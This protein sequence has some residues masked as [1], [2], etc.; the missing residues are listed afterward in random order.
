MDNKHA[1]YDLKQMQS[2]PLG[3]KIEMSKRRIKEWYEYWDGNVY[4]SF[5]GGKDSTVLLR[6]VREIYPDV[7]GVFVDTGL[8][9]PEIKEFVKTSDNIDWI[10]PERS[11]RDVIK[12]CGY[13]IISK[14]VA[15]KIKETRRKPDGYAAQSFDPGSE[16]NKK[17]PS[18]SLMR[19]KYLLDA[20]FLISDECCKI[21]KKTPIKRYEKNTGLHPILGTMA[22]ESIN[23]QTQW[24]KHGCN[25]FDEKRPVSRPISFWTQQDVLDYIRK[26]QVPYCGVY[27]KII[28]DESGRLSTTGVDR[29]GCMFCMFGVQCEKNLNRFQRMKVTHPKQYSYCIRPVEDHGLGIGEVLDYIGVDY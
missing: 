22:C 20:P 17:Y 6:L 1:P 12:E 26:Y 16:K 18:F 25:G 3:A 13:P 2:L 9:Y 14:E 11:F 19:Y 8:E 10:K 15:L 28:E 7:V 4:V 23:R 21:M 29:T 27:G 5:S 24:S